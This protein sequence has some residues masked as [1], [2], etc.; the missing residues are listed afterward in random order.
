MMTGYRARRCFEVCRQSVAGN[1]GKLV[2]AEIDVT[3]RPVCA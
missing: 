2:A 3:R 1:V